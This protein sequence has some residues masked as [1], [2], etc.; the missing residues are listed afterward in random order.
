MKKFITTISRRPLEKTEQGVYRSENSKKLENVIYTRYPIIP[1]IDC[2]T[3]DGEEIEIIAVASSQKYDEER[4]YVNC[5]EQLEAFEEELSN[6]CH[7]RYIKYTV[8]TILTPFGETLDNH[9]E[10]FSK[11]ISAV[12]DNDTHFADITAGP[13]PMPIVQMIALNYCTKNKKN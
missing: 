10:M 8:K 13:K 4:L 3:E 2:Y 6:I 11:I 9:L 7:R 12:S 5:R 1:V